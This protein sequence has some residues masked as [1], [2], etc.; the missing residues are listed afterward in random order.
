V[1][2]SLWPFI[3]LLMVAWLTVPLTTAARSPDEPVV[4]AVLFYSP[5]CPACHK[6]IK[7]LLTPMA[8]Q[9]GDRLQ[10]MAIDTSQSAGLELYNAAVQRYHIE[11]QGVPT[12]VISDV[13]LIGSDEIQGRFPSLV[14]EGLASGIAWPD[15]P[16]LNQAPP[17]VQMTISSKGLQPIGTQGAST[18]LVGRTLTGAMLGGMIAALGYGA[19]RVRAAWQNL[20]K[21]FQSRRKPLPQAETWAIPILAVMGLGIATYL[22]YVEISHVEAICGPIGGCNFVQSSPYAR[23]LGIPVAVLGV[24]YYLAIGVLWA[25][26]RSSAREW[27]N[28]SVLGLLGLAFIGTLFSIYLTILEVF[29]VRAICTWCLSSAVVATVLMLLIVVAV[30]R[31]PAPKRG[32]R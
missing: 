19:S 20:A 16:G 32:R 12:L 15:I 2:K 11:E 13:V 29:V 30:T 9:Y 5:T 25:G 24:L 6:V 7:E 21:L 1:R 8:G 26:Q 17:E 31:I 4:Q 28:R 14:E 3:V 27:A 22:A 10:I 23:I 18:G